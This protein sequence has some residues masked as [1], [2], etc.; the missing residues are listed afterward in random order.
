MYGRRVPLQLPAAFAA[1]LAYLSAGLFMG[2]NAP[3]LP[4]LQQNSSHIVLT[5]DEASWLGAVGSLALVPTVVAAAVLVNTVGRRWLL[6]ASAVPFLAAAIWERFATT[7]GELMAAVVVASLGIGLV[8]PVSPVYLADIAEDRMRGLLVTMGSLMSS[9]GSLLTNAVAPY[10]SFFTL[11]EVLMIF[12]VV[13]V[14]AFWWMPESP[15]F[16]VVKGR[17]QEAERA[18]MRLRGKDSAKD[19]SGEVE[20][21]QRVIQEESKNRRG[22]ADGLRELRSSAVARKAFAVVATLTTLNIFCGSPAMGAYAT[23]IFLWSGSSLDPDVSTIIVNSIQTISSLSSSLLVDCTGRRPLLMLSYTG[24]SIFMIAEGIYFYLMDHGS[25]ELVE[26]LYWLPLTA[27]I[28]FHLLFNIGANALIWVVANEL[29]P[30]GVRSLT[31]SFI[32]VWNAVLTSATI[33]LFQVVRSALGT[34]VCFWFFAGCAATALLFT[35]FFIPETKGRSLEELNTEMRAQA[36]ADR[37]RHDAK[38][39]S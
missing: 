31:I 34:Y 27:L 32:A 10:V 8:I 15:Y 25:D 20:S 35:V 19:V 26:S 17:T 39:R 22:A 23:Q 16:L 13:F 12:P 1:S 5:E 28:S 33:K 30:D 21:I 18:L 9:V 3:M 7:F 14:A 2:W 29:V 6:L 4:R 37:A 24:S 38:H 36:A 11:C